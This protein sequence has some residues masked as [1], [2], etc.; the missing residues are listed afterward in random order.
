MKGNS[1]VS[2]DTKRAH[3]DFANRKWHIRSYIGNNVRRFLDD[4]LVPL[5]FH[6]ELASRPVEDGDAFLVRLGQRI[7]DGVE[8]GARHGPEQ[9]LGK[10][11]RRTAVDLALAEILVF[12][13]FFGV[14]A[15]CLGHVG[16]AH[17]IPKQDQEA[18]E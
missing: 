9:P 17:V 1:Y 5:L 7:E 14:A 6:F 18:F 10:R 16:P 15:L 13:L 12:D 3:F 4:P 2:P 11:H 8:I